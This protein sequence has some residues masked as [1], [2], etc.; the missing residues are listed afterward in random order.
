M[1]TTR[2][3][4]KAYHQ[5][6]GFMG[7]Y[8]IAYGAYLFTST[9]SLPEAPVVEK[10]TFPHLRHWNRKGVNEWGLPPAAEDNFWAWSEANKEASQTFFNRDD[11]AMFFVYLA[12]QK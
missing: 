2:S 6:F 12:G 10:P 3:F 9:E 1:Q 5:F 7:C 8:Q 4:P 11:F